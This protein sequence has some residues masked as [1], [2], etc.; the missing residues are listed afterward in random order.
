MANI[1]PSTKKIHVEF[2]YEAR[3]FQTFEV[4][5]NYVIS[6]GSQSDAYHELMTNFMSN[7]DMCLEHE[8]I[9][10]YECGGSKGVFKRFG[11]F[12]ES[13][14]EQLQVVDF[15]LI[16]LINELEEENEDEDE[17]F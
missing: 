14:N 15:E 8:P 2:F 6:N 9:D 11:D 1:A 13:N 10:I 12:I 16:E 7:V 5:S 3:G 17:D 4:P